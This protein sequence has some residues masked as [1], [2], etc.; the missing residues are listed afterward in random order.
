MEVRATLPGDARSAAA[1]RRFVRDALAGWSLSELAEAAVLLVS[2]LVTNSVLHARSSVDLVLQATGDTF[3]VEVHDGSPQDARRQHFSVESGT[4]RGLAMV[5]ALAADW[6]VTTTAEGKYVW[7]S[8]P[9][10]TIRR[11]DDA[12]A[13]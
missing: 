8:L 10:G 3:R 5:E 4:G 12:E 13:G 2:E 7:F 9:I 11:L 6:G 1:A